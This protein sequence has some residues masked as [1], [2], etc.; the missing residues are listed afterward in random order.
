MQMVSYSSVFACYQIGSAAVE[1]LLTIYLCMQ[2][3]LLK[4]QIDHRI[5]GCSFFVLKEA[6]MPS[7]EA[8]LFCHIASN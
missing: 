1:M 4:R 7:R 5:R 2:G 3:K 8:V 6:K